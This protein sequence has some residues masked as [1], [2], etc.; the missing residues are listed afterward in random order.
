LKKISVK[1]IALIAVLASVGLWMLFRPDKA[2]ALQEVDPSLVTSVTTVLPLVKSNSKQTFIALSESSINGEM[3]R[4][5][6]VTAVS[7]HVVLKSSKVYSAQNKLGVLEE[8]T[9]LYIGPIQLIK[10]TRVP[11]PIFGDLLPNYLWAT[12]KLR[13]VDAQP[14]ADFPWKLD[15]K[16][17]ATL[18]YDRFYSSGEKD[19][20]YDARLICHAIEQI[21][22]DSVHAKLSGIAMKV[23]CEE[24][25]NDATAEYKVIEKF[26]S[27]YLADLQMSISSNYELE[28]G[29]QNQSPRSFSIRKKVI[30]VSV[31]Q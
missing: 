22:A 10:H 29:T 19:G 7:P 14:S 6:V 26:D 31:S 9:G 5:Q 30:D 1:K 13:R 17:V 21:N 23:K 15:S 28:A 12:T 2:A 24:T 11:L 3:I 25:A 4:K 8:L 18:S 20:S 27:W 16:F